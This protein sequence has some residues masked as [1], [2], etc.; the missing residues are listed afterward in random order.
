MKKK[1]SK[2]AATPSKSMAAMLNEANSVSKIAAAVLFIILP[3]VGFYL[4]MLYQ[5]MVQMM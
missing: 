5:Q 1:V 3:F 4:G 2:V